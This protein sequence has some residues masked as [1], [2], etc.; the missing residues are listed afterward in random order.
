VANP[1]NPSGAFKDL[2]DPR[3]GDRVRAGTNT[4]YVRVFNRTRLA[5]NA[6][7][8]VFQVPTADPV[9][10]TAW[11][12]IGGPVAV[13]AIPSRGWR[14]ATIPWTG[15]ADPDPGNPDYKA[16]TLMAVAN[17]TGIGGA[18]LDPFPDLAT[19]TDLGSFWRFFLSA[20]LANNAA[21]RAVRF[22]AP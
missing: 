6:N 20:P 13:A 2:H 9:P 21:M 19:V 4:I 17:V 5:A 3:V 14:F 16:F 10:G 12:A 8:R 1:N 15:V 11:T 7:V 22:A 18:E